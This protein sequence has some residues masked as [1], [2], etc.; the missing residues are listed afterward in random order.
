MVQR[1]TEDDWIWE[2]PW[3]VKYADNREVESAL[4][5]IRARF[6][7]ASDRKTWIQWLLRWD[8]ELKLHPLEVLGMPPRRAENLK[9]YYY[10]P[11][12]PSK[13][14]SGYARID[15]ETQ[16]III[17]A[18]RLRFDPHEEGDL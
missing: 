13:P 4:E 6:A 17:V 15:R 7:S 1:Q 8:A 2:T 5:R 16:A 12:D 10:F 11:G 9:D 3:E 18:I 14:V